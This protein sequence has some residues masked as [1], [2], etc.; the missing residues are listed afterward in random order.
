MVRS[1]IGAMGVDAHE[2][3]A[4]TEKIHTKQCMIL[5]MMFSPFIQT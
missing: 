2:A 1:S 3:K 5:F 4:T